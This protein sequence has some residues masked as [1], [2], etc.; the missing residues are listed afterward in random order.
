MGEGEVPL[1]GYLV[2]VIYSGNSRT[3]T[4]SVIGF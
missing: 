1:Y 4:Q 2:H 3:R